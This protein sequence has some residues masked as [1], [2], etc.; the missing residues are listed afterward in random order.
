MA[1]GIYSIKYT[2]QAGFGSAVAIFH[3]GEIF[4]IDA[5]GGEYTGTYQTTNGNI[6]GQ[7]NL[8]VPAGVVLVTGAPP[9]ATPYTVPI[10]FSFP[11]T[12]GVQQT[13][14]TQV[15]LPTGAVNANIKKVK[16]LAS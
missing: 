5:A 6:A 4:G 2:G 11:A 8:Q 12:I 9:S 13:V 14:Q 7:L 1:D 10:N 15:R 16:N 3:G